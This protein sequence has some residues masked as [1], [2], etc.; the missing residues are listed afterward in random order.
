MEL[1][2]AIIKRRTRYAL[3]G[4]ITVEQNRLIEIVEYAVKNVPS[5][6]NM[7]DTRALI[8]FGD[9]HRKV[10]DIT[11]N[12]LK[13]I[14]PADKFEATDKKIESFK[15]GNGTVLY[16]SDTDTVKALQEK[17]PSYKDNFTI[18]AQQG[19]GMLQYM[20]WTALA[21]EGIGASLQHYNPLIDEDVK[22]GFNLPAGWVLAAQMPFGVAT[23]DPDDKTFLPIEERVKIFK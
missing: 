14:V 18:W 2:E 11:K 22:K 23:A 6:F 12:I 20:V 16:F 7:Q 8:V 19:M 10:W 17:F 9:H 21:S 5:A 13:G 1:Y 15:A 3:S 4:D